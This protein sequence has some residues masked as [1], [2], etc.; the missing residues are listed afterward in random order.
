MD[1]ENTDQTKQETT[2]GSP[3]KAEALMQQLAPRQRALLHQVLKSYPSL[4][5]E[6]ALPQLRAD[7]G[8]RY[9]ELAAHI[10]QLRTLRDDWRSRALAAGNEVAR[11]REREAA[12]LAQINSKTAEALQQAERYKTILREISAQYPLG[13]KVLLDGFAALDKAGLCLNVGLPGLAA[14]VAALTKSGT[15]GAERIM[16]DEKTENGTSEAVSLTEIDQALAQLKAAAG[17]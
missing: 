12:L 5:I 16:N 4:S 1:D 13:G 6:E 3:L 17:V 2:A 14:L 10:D 11:L 15:A 9:F 7:A 8:R